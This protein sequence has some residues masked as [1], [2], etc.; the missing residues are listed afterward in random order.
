MESMPNK[1]QVQ[2]RRLKLLLIQ[3]QLMDNLGKRSTPEY[4][5]KEDQLIILK[6]EIE[7]D[8]GQG[9]SLVVDDFVDRIKQVLKK[10]FEHQHNY[11]QL[12]SKIQK[13]LPFKPDIDALRNLR[14]SIHKTIYSSTRATSFVELDIQLKEVIDRPEFGDLLKGLWVVPVLSNE[15]INE[16]HLLL[17]HK[18]KWISEALVQY[19]C[20]PLIVPEHL[21][22][23]MASPE[24]IEVDLLGN[25][26]IYFGAHS[27]KNLDGFRQDF[28]DAT[29]E[30]IFE[31]IYKDGRRWVGIGKEFSE[32][33]DL[34][35]EGN[36]EAGERFCGF[37]KEFSK[38]TKIS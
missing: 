34:L 11:K 19:G 10:K 38:K 30:L 24:D 35:Y 12:L 26:Y 28:D 37:G 7:E 36:Y 1:L 8:W 20:D 21:L 18:L 16:A 27:T 15:N 29:G 3:L 32:D 6:K 23:A 22:L 4:K 31:G 14:E 25:T 13:V 17:I 5:E 9:A 33:G 2:H